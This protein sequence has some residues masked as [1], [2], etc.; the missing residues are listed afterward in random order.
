[1]AFPRAVTDAS[2]NIAAPQ[3][4]RLAAL[5]QHDAQVKYDIQQRFELYVGVNNLTDQKP[6]P[7]SFFTNRPISPL[8]R[9]YYAGA[10]FNLRP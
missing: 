10:R 6:D 4:R 3:Y 9:Y 7:A 8:G 2:P 5:W 1:R